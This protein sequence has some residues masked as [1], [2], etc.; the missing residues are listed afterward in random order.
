MR[1]PEEAHVGVRA[2]LVRRLG[3]VR[4]E[5]LALDAGLQ[6]TGRSERVARLGAAVE[7]HHALGVHPPPGRV[8][9]R[10]AGG[11]P[12]RVVRAWQREDWLH[13]QPQVS[14]VLGKG[15]ERGGKSGDRAGQI[16]VEFDLGPSRVGPQTSRP[17]GAS[18]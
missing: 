7:V 8:H 17:L 13:F 16:P 1:R 9:V 12:A 6:I 2:G 4:L 5:V 15:E 10:G 11:A 3:R 18:C 14:D